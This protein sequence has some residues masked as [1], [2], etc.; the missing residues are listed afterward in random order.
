MEIVHTDNVKNLISFP[1]PIGTGTTARCYKSKDGDVIK[2]YRDNSDAR[3]LLRTDNFEDKL[4]QMGEISN[5]TFIA[6]K[7]LLYI[8]NKLSG[9]IYDYVRAKDLD[10]ISKFTKLSSVFGH[11]DI[12]LD[13]L[14]KISN[15]NFILRDVHGRNI[16]FNG[17]YHVID[18]DRGVFEDYDS[19]TIYMKNSREVFATVIDQIYGLKPWH[20]GTYSYVN[21]NKYK[22]DDDVDINL[23]HDFCED[24]RKA[25]DDEDP[26]IRKIRKVTLDR[27]FINTYSF[28]DD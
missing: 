6:P 27:K 10:R 2:V 9:Y 7:K 3:F 18:L 12:V 21:V 15:K 5:D 20:E 28:E 4:A 16:L 11:F 13:N 1:L 8:N 25:C 22:Y 14:K 24:I 17:K 23:V 26:T 19:R